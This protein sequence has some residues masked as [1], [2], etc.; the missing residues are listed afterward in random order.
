MAFDGVTPATLLPDV[1]ALL[2]EKLG[3]G[4]VVISGD[5]AA[6]SLATGQP[7][8]DLAVAAVKAGCDLL[9][10]PGDAGDQDAAWRA[11]VRA[12]RTGEVPASRVAEA[13]TRVSV[14]RARYGV[15]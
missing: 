5:L 1:V 10:V 9:W 6:A 11:V 4:G 14:L 8:A 15:R 3:F 7:V 13:L 2:R 12:L